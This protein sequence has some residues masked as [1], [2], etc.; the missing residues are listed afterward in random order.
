MA[1][2]HPEH[3]LSPQHALSRPDAETLRLVVQLPAVASMKELEVDLASRAVTVSG[4]AGSLTVDLPVAVDA[5]SERLR[6][7]FSKKSRSLRIDMPVVVGA[8]PTPPRRRHRRDSTV[9]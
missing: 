3:A 4:A 6:A 7:K 8:A 2:H 5:E 1:V 9:D